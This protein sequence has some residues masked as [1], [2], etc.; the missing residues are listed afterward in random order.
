MW[1]I[2]LREDGTI[3]AVVSYL[4]PKFSTDFFSLLWVKW[5]AAQL[6]HLL[7]ELVLSLSLSKVVKI[8]NKSSI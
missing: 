6:L 4:F 8:K 3:L 7:F 1:I 2:S 5:N